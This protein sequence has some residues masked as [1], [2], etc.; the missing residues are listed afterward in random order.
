MNALGVDVSRWQRSVDWPKLRAAGVSFAVIKASQGTLL[1]DSLLRS[2]F[3]GARD[4]GMVAGVYHWV[5]PTQ[6]ARRQI[7]HFLQTCEGLDFDFAALDVEQYWQSWQEWG[8]KAVVSRVAPE[9]LSEHARESAEFLRASTQ[10][11]VVIYTR[12]SFVADY[13]PPMQSWLPDWSLWLA[14][15]PYP[16]GRVNLTWERLL[17]QQLPRISAPKLPPGCES[18]RFW[19]FSAD[20]FVLPGAGSPLD[21]NFFKGSEA[22]LRAWVSKEQAEK[23][24]LGDAEKLARLW[25]AHPELRLP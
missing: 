15:Y 21:L 7:Y 9:R 25:Q 12:A 14:Y 18:W 13:A 17:E 23:P 5:D 1:T 16:S 24:A 20:R 4:A 8:S 6:P 2:H 19:Q 11:R 22:D 10:K 3:T